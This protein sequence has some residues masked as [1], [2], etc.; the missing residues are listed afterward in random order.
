MP[1]QCISICMPRT[2][3]CP[4]WSLVLE[5]G[6]AISFW[7]GLT[8]WQ[9]GAR[10]LFRLLWPL[11]GLGQEGRRGKIK[12]TLPSQEEQKGRSS[13]STT[14]TNPFT[15][16]ADHQ[17]L[18]V[19]YSFRWFGGRLKY[20]LLD[21]FLK[22]NYISQKVGC[23]YLCLLFPVSS[24]DADRP[25]LVPCKLLFCWQLPWNFIAAVLKEAGTGRGS[26]ELGVN[27]CM[28]EVARGAALVGLRRLWRWSTCRITKCKFTLSTTG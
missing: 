11:I 26:M 3:S 13:R 22:F 14:I 27:W 9:T 6:A 1:I 12:I 21:R 18:S 28:S 5:A 16:S 19:V 25:G 20:T 4:S 2:L 17:G 10:I 7:E 8:E 15:K 24:S 23:S